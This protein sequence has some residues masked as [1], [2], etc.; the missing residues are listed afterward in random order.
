ML[1]P[2]GS[3]SSS[4]H[5]QNGKP[6]IAFVVQRCGTEVNGGAE[7]LCFQ[8]A[9]RMGRFWDTEILTTC[10]LDY[11]QWDN[12]Y[13]IGSD[14]VENT[15]VRRF[16]VDSPRNV[17]SF[18]QISS[19]LL[20]KAGA[21]TL[22]EQ[23]E[24]MRAQGPLSSGLLQYLATATE[25]YDAFIFF[26][27][28][29][30][31]TYF[32]LPLVMGKAYLAP[33]GHDEWTIQLSMWDKFFAKPHGFIFQTPEE[34]SFLQRRFPALSLRGPITGVGIEEPES[35]N[36]ATFRSSYNLDGP[37][38]LYV[39][40]VDASKGCAEM[41]DWF[42]KRPTITGQNLKLVVIGAE[43]YPVPFHDNII[44]LGFVSEKEKWNAM[45]ACD[46][47]LLPSRYE[48]LS[49]SLL[50][51]WI[52][53]RPAIV[54]SE[55]EVLRGHCRRAHGA[56]CYQDWKEVDAILAFVSDEAKKTLG[57]QGRDYVR[58]NYSWRRLEEDY[59][60]IVTPNIQ[61]A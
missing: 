49:L 41:F 2:T 18:N 21:A 11:M 44:Y 17:A 60:S 6:R 23:E 47:L 54:N 45:N 53:G 24:W 13:P 56:L 22:A 28:L 40:R 33:L 59:R 26:G 46:W 29:Y 3:C 37:F 32:G 61:V 35:F 25:D 12:Y 1:S 20:H 5:G 36:P 48:S 58:K 15:L 8:M 31:T 4:A 52:A 7:S 9:Q 27:Y 39:G 50:E 34:L 57:R 55:S 51:T 42:L 16:A 19:A 38:L 30:A 10:A 43:V 14:L